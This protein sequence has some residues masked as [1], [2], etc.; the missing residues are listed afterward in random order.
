MWP[1]V[2]VFALCLFRRPLASL[3]G[4]ATELTAFGLS[5]KTEK[6]AQKLAIRSQVLPEVTTATG[7]ADQLV[8]YSLTTAQPTITGKEPTAGPFGLSSEMQVFRGWVELEKILRKLSGEMGI[9]P[10]PVVDVRRVADELRK[11]KYISDETAVF[12]GDLQAMRND[13]VDSSKV[14]FLTD[15]AA[16]SLLISINQ[17]IGV[18]GRIKV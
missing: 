9:P 12:I 16:D 18:L 17:I 10:G 14:A 7:E 3:L 2:L 11:R 5:I 15:S 1:A 8:A 13:L 6:D 4:R